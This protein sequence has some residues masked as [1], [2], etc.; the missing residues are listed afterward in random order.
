[1]GMNSTRRKLAIATWSAPREGNI[2]G[3]LTVDATNAQ[4]YL[5][6]LHERSGQKVTL[7]HFVGKAV[8]MAM[9]SSYLLGRWRA[10]LIR[11]L[12]SVSLIIRGT[13]ATPFVR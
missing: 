6:E 11:P 4:A 7:T 5:Q 10:P 3:K 12:I 8:A 9:A 1:M 13:R 2:Y